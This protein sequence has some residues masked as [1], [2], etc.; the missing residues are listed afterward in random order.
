ML[1]LIPHGADWSLIPAFADAPFA[2]APKETFEE[3]VSSPC[4]VFDCEAPELNAE[5]IAGPS[6]PGWSNILYTEK[7][8]FSCKY[9]Y[10]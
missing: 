1:L 8:I 5:E 6:S 2:V 7:F 9:M 3:I 4:C 10:L